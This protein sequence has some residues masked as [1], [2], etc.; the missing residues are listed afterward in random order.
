ML[1]SRSTLKGEIERKFSSLHST[2][3]RKNSIQAREKI[4]TGLIETITSRLQR[5]LGTSH[6]E[7]WNA[8]GA[9]N[10]GIERK[11]A[12]TP[13]DKSGRPSHTPN[14][15]GFL[16]PDSYDRCQIRPLNTQAAQ[17]RGRPL[18]ILSRKSQWAGTYQHGQVNK[19]RANNRHN[20]TCK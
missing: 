7:T 19:K 18:D 1:F 13:Y 6:R 11:I 14:I 9:E 15:K 12:P 20:R 3:N 16:P 17:T 10:G 4:S 8:L 5:D 2:G